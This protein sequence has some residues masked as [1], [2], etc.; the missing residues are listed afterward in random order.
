MSTRLEDPLPGANLPHCEV[1]T[2]LPFDQHGLVVA[3]AQQFDKRS[4]S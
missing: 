1:L 2:D 3:I 4:E